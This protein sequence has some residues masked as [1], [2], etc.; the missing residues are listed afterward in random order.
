MS[1]YSEPKVTID[2]SEYHNLK[3]QV[4]AKDEVIACME[5]W[6]HDHNILPPK[7]KEK[8]KYFV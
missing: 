5:Q 2:L 7:P 4:K 8:T 3:A 1:N 6:F